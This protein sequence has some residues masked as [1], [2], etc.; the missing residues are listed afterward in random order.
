RGRHRG[1]AA[2]PEGRG[3]GRPPAPPE[4]ARLRRALAGHGFAA[5]DAAYAAASA[6]R[7][8]IRGGQR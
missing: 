5:R 2:A 7:R 3:H 8:T 1:A 4:P 6:A